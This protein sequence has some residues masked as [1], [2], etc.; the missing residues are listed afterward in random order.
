MVSDNKHNLNFVW[1][2]LIQIMLQP[3]LP[4]IAGSE[5]LEMSF[6]IK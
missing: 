2:K 3:P 5:D 6:P 1:Q 4:L